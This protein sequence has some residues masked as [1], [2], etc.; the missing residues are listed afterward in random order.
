[1]SVESFVNL[2]TDIRIAEASYGLSYNKRDT[3]RASMSAVYDSLYAAH[4]TSKT[5]FMQA[6]Q[7]YSLSTEGMLKIEDQIM[8]RLSALQAAKEQELIDLPAM[9]AD[10][11]KP[12]TFIP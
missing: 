1:M 3:L 11:L 10:T 7:Y 9:P 5:P 12:K 6:Y 4:G 2:L 8:E